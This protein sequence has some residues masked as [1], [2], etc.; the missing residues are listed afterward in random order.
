MISTLGIRDAENLAKASKPGATKV[1]V[2]VDGEKVDELFT[3]GPLREGMQ[4]ES[5][6]ISHALEGRRVVNISFSGNMVTVSTEPE[7]G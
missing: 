7:D 5:D 3:E 4:L 6:M 2:F 1:D